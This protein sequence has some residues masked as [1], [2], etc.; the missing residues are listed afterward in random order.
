[1]LVESHAFFFGIQ[2]L[3]LSLLCYFGVDF[4]RFI[5]EF[6]S[7]N[8]STSKAM[9]ELLLPHVVLRL[10]PFIGCFFIWIAV[11]ASLAIL[12]DEEKTLPQEFIFSSEEDIYFTPPKVVA[13]FSYLDFCNIL[14]LLLLLAIF[15]PVDLYSAIHEYLPALC[16]ESS[17]FLI[18]FSLY[19]FVLLAKKEKRINFVVASIV[20]STFF[21]IYILSIE[22][23][24]WQIIFSLHYCIQLFAN[25]QL[26]RFGKQYFVQ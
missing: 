12:K 20:A 15:V 26:L 3:F 23:L 8:T 9:A 24:T 7:N 1:M 25:I 22:N 13:A 17:L 18:Y 21:Y 5:I 11:R 16:Q 4:V 14:F 10:L 19:Y 2:T 6:V